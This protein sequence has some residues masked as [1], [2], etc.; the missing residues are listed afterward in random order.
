MLIRP[1]SLIT[2]LEK[3]KKCFRFDFWAILG[4]IQFFTE[5]SSYVEK[6]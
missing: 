6:S 4:N 3:N 5:L 1:I 2:A